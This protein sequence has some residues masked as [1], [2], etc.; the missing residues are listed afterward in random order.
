MNSESKATISAVVVTWNSEKTVKATLDSLRSQ[1]IPVNIIVV[2][3]ASSDSTPD[4]IKEN[5]PE[6]RL[7]LN[8][9]NDGFARAN[10]TGISLTDS[11]WV[12]LLNP[13]AWI[14]NDFIEKL[15]SFADSSESRIGMLGGLLLTAQSAVST[16]LS[17][18]II[19]SAGI[20][21]FRSRRVRDKLMGC[22]CTEEHNQ[23]VQVF[24]VCAAAVLYRREMLEDIA[25]EG[26]IFPESF[27]S[28]YEDADLAWRAWRRGWT[29]W[30]VPDAIGY[31]HRGGSTTG[32]KFSRYL[33]H[34]NRFWMIARNE[35]LSNLITFLPELLIHEF[36]MLLRVI[37]FP[38]LLKAVFET[39]IGL[40][41]AQDQYKKVPS[42]KDT[43][44][45]FQR[46]IGF[47]RS[48]SD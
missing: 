34:R 30:F 38:Y 39:T 23:S 7:V 29:A 41:R 14:E 42:T 35:L 10:N 20:E 19:D 24:G 1:T 2:D 48:K 4:L 22:P 5:Y 11:E 44:P 46:G 21:I 40:K 47:G 45:P 37:R 12:L 43:P 27:F 16:P 31:H 3:N 26:E 8:K 28:Y 15:L 17:T 25:V 18:P 13:D 36:L 6:I 32:D 33:T 9:T